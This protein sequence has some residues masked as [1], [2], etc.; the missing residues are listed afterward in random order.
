MAVETAEFADEEARRQ[1][2]EEAER[3]WNAMFP[4]APAADPAPVRIEW[5]K[6]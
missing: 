1:H 4:S 2:N 5:W 6:D 3:Q